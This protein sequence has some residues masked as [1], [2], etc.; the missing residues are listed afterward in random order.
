MRKQV[1]FVLMAM[2][3]GLLFAAPHSYL[4]MQVTQPDGSEISVYASGD[5]F[6]NWLHDQDNYTIVRDDEGWYVYA[7]QDG[8][9]VAPTS[10]RAGTGLAQRSALTP[11]I[12]LSRRLVEEKYER[13]SQMRDYSNARA[14]HIGAINNL[15]V[16]IKFSD[17]PDFTRPLSYYGNMF[18]DDAEGANS[19][20]NYF[21]AAS[22][23]LLDVE[24]YFYP[25]PNG[26]VIVS[27][28]DSHPRSYYQPQSTSNPNGYN[29]NS[30]WERTERE[31]TLLANACAYVANQIPS[32]LNIDGDNDGYV[33]NV[34]FIIQG[35]TDGWAELLWPHRWVLYD[36]TAYINGARVWDFNF[37]LENSLDSS[38]ASVLSHEM[39]HSLGAPDLYRYEDTTISPIGSWDLMSGNAN[40]PQHMSA[41]MKYK[42][43]QWIEIPPT[44]TQSGTYSIYPVATH[45]HDNAFRIA[46]WKSGEYY[47]IEYRRA[48]GI[49]DGNIPGQGLLVYRLLPNVG[50][51]ADGPPDELYIYRPGGVDNYTNGNLSGAAFSPTN[52]RKKMNEATTPS[53]FS[54][55]GTPGGL[56]I[57]NI[58]HNEDGVTFDIH[59][60]DIKLVSPDGDENWFSGTNKTIQWK[61]K[62]IGG[63]VDIEYTTDAGNSWSTIASGVT[64][65]GSYTWTNIPMLF[66]DQAK[67]RV[68]LNSNGHWDTS[69]DFFQIIGELAVPETIYPTNA[70]IAVETNPTFE[71]EA[72]P[73]A[74]GYKLQLSLEED[75]SEL[76]LELNEHP[77]AYYE[78]SRLLPYTQ[79]FWK[80]ASI[81]EMGSSDFS[82]VQSFTTGDITENPDTPALIAPP[83][84]A[85]NQPLDTLLQWQE[86]DL[87]ETYYLQLSNNA[88]F[89]DPILELGEITQTNYRLSNLQPN[90]N[91]Y[92]RIGAV[93]GYGSSGFSLARRFG[94]GN[95]ISNEDESS[96]ALENKLFPNY[97]NPFNPTTTI[98]FSLKEM[99]EEITLAIYNTRGQKIKTLY[100]GLPNSATMSL[101]WD[102]K[103]ES[104]NSVSSGIYLYRLRSAS[105]SD[106]RKMLLS[107]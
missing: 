60:S 42:Y 34:C 43:G 26:D 92:W 58:S 51:N 50:G 36:S 71:W 104:G 46:S 14:P 91:Y 9:G 10:F 47:V 107:K 21:D 100:H 89:T 40:P 68:T 82:A 41:W 13:L 48:H 70:S 59:I 67:I 38:G 18:N 44:I 54:S 93:N 61:T 84:M 62:N 56:K 79:Y 49:Y 2:L 31:H 45:G 55:T 73:G 17:S 23:G 76:V 1:L 78:A 66:S 86:A 63:T 75:F 77:R 3:F 11:G 105:F 8:E 53:G 20:R 25:I 24:S 22:Y 15:V 57:F 7:R 39:F 90:R 64:N 29:E 103:D 33:D 69:T 94:T 65:N 30:Y 5:E 72:V 81:N 88:Y 16:F 99:D 102:G 87:A 28:V 52:N 101:N 37:Q 4:P 74:G 6:H 98:S 32:S 106:T 80:V 19:M 95:W 12:N 27:Y 35:A 83:H 97:P 96:P 85:T